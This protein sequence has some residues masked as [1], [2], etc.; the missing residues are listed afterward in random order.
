MKKNKKKALKKNTPKKISTFKRYYLKFQKWQEGEKEK[1]EMKKRDINYSVKPKGYFA[2]KIGVIFFW[3]LFL[4][5]FLVVI[6]TL[7]SGGDD[8]NAD[9][10]LQVENNQAT[11]PEAIQFA[12]NF[13]KDYFTWTATNDG[14]DQRKELMIKYVAEGIRNHSG[15]SIPNMD[16]NSTFKNAELKRITEKGTNLAY[17]TFL[18]EY[19]YVEVK[20]DKKKDK[21]EKKKIQKYIDVPIAFDGH[22]YG[23]YELPKFSYVYEDE[24]TVKE[25]K[26]DR[27]NQAESEATNSIQEFLPTFFKTYAEDEKDKLNFMITDD[28]VTDG[29]NGTMRFDKVENSKIYKGQ[30]DNQFIVFA[31][32]KLIDPETE[33]KF[34]VTHQLEL[35][36]QEDRFLVSG[37]NNYDNK[38]V[39]SSIEDDSNDS[40]EE[41][42]D[43]D[44]ENG[45]DDSTPEQENEN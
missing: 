1:K 25:V 14:K 38:G 16:W 15:L 2:R 19:E 36:K 31:E 45:E 10:L 41:V 4:F 23:V 26:Y 43:G 11:S 17:L 13:L 3:S 40:S 32:V 9:E 24:T 6:V 27:M 8:S 20:E 35:V 34:N 30:A 33:T 21:P 29:L 39:I 22:S 7:F 44:T 28:N 18:V 12:E 42:I 37:M 5:M